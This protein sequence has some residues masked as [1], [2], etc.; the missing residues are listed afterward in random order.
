MAHTFIL[1][2]RLFSVFPLPLTLASHIAASYSLHPIL[3]LL[4]FCPY[5]GVG[6]SFGFT[7]PFPVVEVTTASTNHSVHHVSGAAYTQVRPPQAMHIHDLNHFFFLFISFSSLFSFY[8]LLLIS[9]FLHNSISI[10]R[11]DELN[12]DYNCPTCQSE[13]CR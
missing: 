3:I 5:A 10:T 13:C 9:M 12:Q 11:S 4:C 8:L 7:I 1:F 6:S 2:S